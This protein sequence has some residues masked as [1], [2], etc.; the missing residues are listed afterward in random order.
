MTI[1]S[2]DVEI[3]YEGTISLVVPYTE[4]AREW[5]EE[6]IGKD[7][8]FQPY[9]PTVVVE[10]RY[11]QDIAMGMLDAGLDVRQAT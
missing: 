5:L 6:F 7:N 11:I 4:A 9:W 2:C 3:R 1:E 8:G 10:A